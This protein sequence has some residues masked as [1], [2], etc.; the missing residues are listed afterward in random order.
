MEVN[1]KKFENPHTRIDLAHLP[2]DIQSRYGDLYCY[3]GIIEH[4]P[5]SSKVTLQSLHGL[6]MMM[7]FAGSIDPPTKGHEFCVRQGLKLGGIPPFDVL[8][9]ESLTKPDKYKLLTPQ[10]RIALLLTYFSDSELE[11]LRFH[12]TTTTMTDVERR[13]TLADF[14]KAAV[15]I[16]KGAREGSDDKEHTI[17]WLISMSWVI[18]GW[19]IC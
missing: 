15:H 5:S 12:F 16:V 14:H 9:V 17:H 18:I 10:A 8:A 11:S 1:C 4:H 3:G 6:E 19:Q 2:N 7:A 13:Q